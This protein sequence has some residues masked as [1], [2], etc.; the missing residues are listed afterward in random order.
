MMA[1]I[2]KA[3]QDSPPWKDGTKASTLSLGIVL[4]G[5]VI[6]GLSSWY[7][8]A[9]RSE[10]KHQIIQ[11]YLKWAERDLKEEQTF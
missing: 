7:T 6:G 5:F 1:L 9:N 11:R 2:V 8:I 4:L 3:I 10:D